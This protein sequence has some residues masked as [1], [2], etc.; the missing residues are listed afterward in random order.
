MGPVKFLAILSWMFP[1]LPSPALDPIKRLTPHHLL[2]AENSVELVWSLPGISKP[3]LAAVSCLV[4]FS[5]LDMSETEDVT[6]A[7]RTFCS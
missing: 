1:Q 5:S 3:C 2:W 7:D 6:H 4:L